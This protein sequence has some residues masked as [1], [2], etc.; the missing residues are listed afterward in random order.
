MRETAMRIYQSASGEWIFFD[1]GEKHFF[2]T[3]SEA[4]IM[5]REQDFITAARAANRK[6]W[7]GINELK[8]L[9]REWAALDY[10]T[11][12]DDGEGSNAGITGVMVGAVVF[13]TADALETTLNAGHATNMARLL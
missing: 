13:A 2:A 3:E 1:G 9:Q 12:L 11:T 5:S 6:A 7:E 10:G 4:W 8:A